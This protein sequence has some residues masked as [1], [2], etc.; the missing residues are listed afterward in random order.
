MKKLA[1]KLNK[2]VDKR[3]FLWYYC[4]ALAREGTRGTDRESAKRTLKIKQRREK[5][6]PIR[7]K[8]F[9]LYSYLKKDT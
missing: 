6:N 7:F 4:K 9:Y 2:S 3:I 1:K 5:R 8:E